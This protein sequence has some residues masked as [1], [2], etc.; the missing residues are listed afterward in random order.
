MV[1][2]A[3]AAQPGQLGDAFGDVEEHHVGDSQ[4]T[5][6]GRRHAAEKTLAA[7]PGTGVSEQSSPAMTPA[8][9]ATG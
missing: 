5:E 8:Q 4:H 9:S 6:G 1:M 7:N 3:E 2:P